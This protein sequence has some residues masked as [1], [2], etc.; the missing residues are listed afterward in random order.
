MSTEFTGESFLDFKFPNCGELKS[1]PQ[2]CMGL[3][4]DCVNCMEN[5]L[6]PGANSESGKRTPLPVS[7]T[8]LSLRRLSMA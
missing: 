4:R 8:R 1:F 6:V 5:L 7:S 3:V 2:D